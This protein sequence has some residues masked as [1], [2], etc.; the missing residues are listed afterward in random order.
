[1][2]INE[3]ACQALFM[4]GT[5]KTI[6]LRTL[7]LA[8]MTSLVLAVAGC[9][10]SG[11]SGSGNGGTISQGNNAQNAA[12]LFYQGS[13]GAVDPANPASPVAVESGAISRATSIFHG[14]YDPVGMKVSD[15]LTRT[16][17]YVKGGQFFKVSALKG[18]GTPTPARLSNETSADTMAGTPTVAADFANHDNAQYIYR[19]AGGGWRMIKVGMGA[20]DAPMPAKQ[21]LAPLYYKPSGALAGWLAVDGSAVKKF[22]ANFS[23]GSDVTVVS[24]ADNAEVVDFTID[25]VFLKVDGKLY[26]YNTG[27]GAVSGVLYTF[28]ASSTAAT[29]AT[30]DGSN[31]YF[32]D[33]G[34]L[35]SVPLGGAA[36]AEQI[37]AETGTIHQLAY[38]DKKVVYVLDDGAQYKLR[39]T[40]K[41]GV[42]PGTAPVDLVTAA[43]GEI[44]IFIGA[45]GN[46]AY[47]D[48]ISSSGATTAGTVLENGLG[49]SETPNAFWVGGS[50]Q[51]I[52]DTRSE[53]VPQY[54]IRAA[55]ITSIVDF[56]GGQLESFD[57]ATG[58]RLVVLGTIPQD[59]HMAEV[60]A[61]AC[62]NRILLEGRTITGLSSYVSDVFYADLAKG[63]SLTRVTSTPQVSEH[64]VPVFN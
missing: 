48:K 41:S 35:L 50:F 31:I 42:A 5:V 55:G 10:G 22:D 40:G 53:V 2:P 17:V 23:A 3:S 49:R 62:G 56:R 51:N 1:M 4:E 21:P 25:T 60:F 34:K 52:F 36:Q 59:I 43:N 44:L 12:Y 9:S 20:A 28:T 39:T 27:S 26:A 37:A 54:F 32:A 47:F 15:T 38:T 33:G 18:G 45:R 29:I 19:T 13:I 8:A 6:K 46:L 63:G 30:K 61:N 7:S 57:A 24:F 64:V 11:G 14:T 16:V 58:S